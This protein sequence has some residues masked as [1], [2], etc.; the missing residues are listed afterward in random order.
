MEW[1]TLQREQYSDKVMM[2]SGLVREFGPQDAQML[3]LC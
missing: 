1:L 3:V 2:D